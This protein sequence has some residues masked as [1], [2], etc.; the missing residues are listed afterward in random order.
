MLKGNNIDEQLLD[1]VQNVCTG[2][3]EMRTKLDSVHSEVKETKKHAK[4]TNG[5]VAAQEKEIHKVHIW[6]A[7]VR[8]ISFV[9]SIVATLIILPMLTYLIVDFLEGKEKRFM[10]ESRVSTMEGLIYEALNEEE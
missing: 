8:A 4:A 7:R 10:L 1:I 9:S 5:K 2:I 3:G 6:Q